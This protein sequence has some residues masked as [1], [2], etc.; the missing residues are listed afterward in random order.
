MNIFDIIG[1]VSLAAYGVCTAAY[2]DSGNAQLVTIYGAVFVT[3]GWAAFFGV[4]WCK[5]FKRGGTP[6]TEDFNMATSGMERSAPTSAPVRPLMA[7][8]IPEPAS[9]AM[10]VSA[11]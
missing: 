9:K 6:D 7:M 1:P 2:L 5:L 11:G 3:V 4:L 10:N 8:P